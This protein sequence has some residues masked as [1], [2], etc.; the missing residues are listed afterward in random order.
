MLAWISCWLRARVI[1]S[2]RHKGSVT[3][4]IRIDR[5]GHFP[6]EMWKVLRNLA[7]EYFDVEPGVRPDERIERPRD[8]R[9]VVRAGPFALVKFQ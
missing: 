3:F 1:N 9:D 4:V 5:V 2:P 6:I 8:P 7:A